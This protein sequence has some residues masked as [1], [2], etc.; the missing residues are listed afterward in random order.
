MEQNGAVVGQ[1]PHFGPIPLENNQQKGCLWSNR[2]E[3]HH[4]SLKHCLHNPKASDRS[5]PA[6][7]A[8]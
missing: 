4:T 3:A 1:V 6:T 2:R 5:H 8:A 7:L